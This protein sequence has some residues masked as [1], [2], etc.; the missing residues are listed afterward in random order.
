MKLKS[1]LKQSYH[2]SLERNLGHPQTSKMECFATIVI[3]LKELFIVAELS[4]LDVH[5]GFG[6]ASGNTIS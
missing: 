3:R 2:H 6:Y 4:K 5:R 1:P